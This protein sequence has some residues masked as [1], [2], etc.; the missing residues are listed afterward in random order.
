MVERLTLKRYTRQGLWSLFLVCAFPLHA[1]TIVLAFRDFSWVAE[2]SSAWDSVGVM[3]YGMVFAFCESLGVFLIAALLGFL[4]SPSW[5]EDR[6][7]ALLN[8]LVLVTAVWAILGQLFFLLNLSPP[9]A[10]VQFLSGSD[11]PLRILYAA[12]LALVVPTVLIPVYLV[13]RSERAV[14]FIGELTGRLAL[15]TAFYLFL[16]LAG[17][18]ILLIRNLA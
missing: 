2:R 16:D 15:L 18:V 5:A 7:I 17:L 3:A 14:R 8:V 1:W 6:R 13:L 4:V 9:A 11:H 12:S 10:L